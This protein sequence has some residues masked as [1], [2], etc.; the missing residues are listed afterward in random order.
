[1]DPTRALTEQGQI[2]GTLRYM[3]PEQLQGKEADVRSDLFAF[4][5]V[6]HEMLTGKQ[7]MG[8]FFEDNTSI[9]FAA[10]LSERLGGFVPPKGF[11]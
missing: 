10:L 2:V 11:A 3:S 7:I 6:L 1:M 9:A 8:P 4:S 5:C